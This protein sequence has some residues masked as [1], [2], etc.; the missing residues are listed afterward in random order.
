MLNL[1]RGDAHLEFFE[2][3][4]SL[5]FGVLGF[6]IFLTARSENVIGSH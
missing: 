3:G 1:G 5:A 6:G 4:I 2:L